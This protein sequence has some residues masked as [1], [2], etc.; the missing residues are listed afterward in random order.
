M[1]KYSCKRCGL[2]TKIR[3]HFSRHLHRKHTCKPLLNNISIEI[4]REE[5]KVVKKDIFGQKVDIF[6][7]LV[8]KK[9]P[10]EYTQNKLV[11]EYCN[12][13]YKS[14]QTKSRHMKMY[15]RERGRQEKMTKLLKENEELKEKISQTSPSVSTNIVNNINNTL[16][17]NDNSINNINNINTITI[18]NY[19]SENLDY[20]T[21][22]YI[23]KLLNT[24]PIQAIRILIKNIHY[25]PEHPENH[26]IRITASNRKYNEASIWKDNKW[27]LRDKRTVIKDIV[28]KSYNILDD[29][30][31]KNIEDGDQHVT[32][33]EFQD[34]YEKNDKTTHKHLGKQAELI[35]MNESKNKKIS[36][37]KSSPTK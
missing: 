10:S 21:E 8:D 36:K 15:C 4:L 3:T 11:C 19:G 28:D 1:V 32:F 14:E 17:N 5:F 27:V 18:N 26:N 23:Q 20:I 25:H 29:E 12:K 34:Q 35:I 7:H 22:Q 37:S 16:T 13:V 9:C 2:E 30:F 6:G 31:I 33:N 24:N